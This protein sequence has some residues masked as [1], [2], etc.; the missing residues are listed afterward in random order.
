MSF[1]GKAK[2]RRG[3]LPVSSDTLRSRKTHDSGRLP[4]RFAPCN[5][6]VGRT[7]PGVMLLHLSFCSS[8]A[9][10]RAYSVWVLTSPPLLPDPAPRRLCCH[11]G[12]SAHPG[13][14]GCRH[15]G[16]RRQ[17]VSDPGRAG[18]HPAWFPDFG[19][20]AR[21]LRTVPGRQR[22]LFPLS[23]RAF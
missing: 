8:A 3:N 15:S 2:P 18:T 23:S 12:R 7:S 11:P 5:D 4:R 16:S 10:L 21:R 20:T 9:V 22:L 14:P 6:S 13:C 17:S 19:R 1:R